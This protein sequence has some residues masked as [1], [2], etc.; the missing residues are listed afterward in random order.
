MQLVAYIVEDHLE[1]LCQQPSA[2][3]STAQKRA[4]LKSRSTLGTKTTMWRSTLLYWRALQFAVDAG[5]RALHVY[6]DSKVVVKQ[7][8]GKYI[9][10]SSRLYS[11]H[12]TCVKLSRSHQFSI[13]HIPGESNTEANGLANSVARRKYSTAS[14]A[15]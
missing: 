5:A 6:Y 4:R 3:S 8:T 13:S 1:I 2:S 9:C 7:M 12:W 10:R 15:D 11:L 14:E